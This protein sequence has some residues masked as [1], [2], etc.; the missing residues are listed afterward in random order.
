MAVLVT[1]FVFSARAQCPPNIG[2][3]KGNFS[4]W[5]C[6][7]GGATPAGPRFLFNGVV[8]NRH[9]IIKNYF[10]SR[11]VDRYGSFPVSC[12]N[13]SGYSVR[14]GNDETGSNA[15]QISYTFKIP[16]DADI[17][18]ILYNYAVAMQSPGHPLNEQPKFTAK[19]FDVD[20]NSYIECSSF[21]FIASPGLPGFNYSPKD[22]SVLFKNWTPVTLKLNGRAGS[23]IRL[24]FTTSD[25]TNGGHFGYAYVDVDENC[26]SS[27]AGNKYCTRDAAV[28][29]VAPAGFS[30][31]RWYNSDFTKLLDSISVLN[32]VP[33]PPNNTVYALVVT[34]FPKLGCTDT[35]YTTIQFSKDTVKLEV[36]NAAACESIGVDVTSLIDIA[37]S[38]DSLTFKYYTNP[39]LTGFLLPADDVRKTGTYYIKATN[40]NDCTAAKSVDVKIY[41]VPVIKIP[42]PTPAIE[43][44][45][46]YDLSTAFEQVPGIT[47]T[48]WKDSLTT[49]PLLNANS[50]QQ[51]GTYYIKYTS[52]DG[53]SNL[54]SVKLTVS[55]PPLALDS[56]PNVFSPN[57]DGINDVWLIPVLRFYPD[58]VI[59]IYTRSGQTV[60]HSAGYNTPW[61]GRYNG[62]LL[63]VG[64][65]YYAIKTGKKRKA[66]GGS[67]TVIR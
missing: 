61:D 23:T 11:E 56:I 45:D 29:L 42:S 8:E 26:G 25:C 66:I 30:D 27:I 59:D 41:P 67:I 54:D 22:T 19:V 10:P 37:N 6:S 34:P 21:D 18:S 48:F 9:T 55:D 16:A 28:R 58:C 2:F 15:E 14:L 50:L 12:P 24:E 63:P 43:N 47:Y 46:V 31:Y 20:N 35:L 32:I 7:T 4:N 40:K 49:Q 65:Y 33:A 57:G 1:L 60:F 53:C 44:P 38:S 39:E 52:S 17:Y 5:Q 3:E 13:G 62:T 64:T 36:K 51:S